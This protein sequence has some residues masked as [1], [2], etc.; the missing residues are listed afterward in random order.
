MPAQAE[1]FDFSRILSYTISDIAG[2]YSAPNVCAYPL[3]WS[4]Q[5]PPKI[6]GAFLLAAAFPCDK[7]NSLQRRVI[8]SIGALLCLTHPV[9]QRCSNMIGGTR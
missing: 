7:F 6:S 1:R 9:A 4:R 8:A 3:R 5:K 2:A